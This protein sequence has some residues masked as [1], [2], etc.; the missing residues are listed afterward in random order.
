MLAARAPVGVSVVH[1]GG[2]KTQIA[3]NALRNAETLGM[4][5]T[6]E[7]RKRIDYYNEKLLKMD[8]ARAA[9]IIVD[10]VEKNRLRIRVGNDAVAVDLLV[11]LLPSQAPRLAVLFSR[12]GARALRRR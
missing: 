4:Q 1:P 3:S 10:G 5:V 8:P 2:V 7:D 9:E 11:R 6:A 12:L